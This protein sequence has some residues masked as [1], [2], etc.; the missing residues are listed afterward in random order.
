MFIIHFKIGHSGL[1]KAFWV[2]LLSN[3]WYIIQLIS[4]WESER[5]PINICSMTSH[6]CNLN[7]K[8]DIQDRALDSNY[9][10]RKQ[11]R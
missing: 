4:E 7:K 1:P 11:I 2:L 3:G 10:M 9:F 6:K 8:C 5:R